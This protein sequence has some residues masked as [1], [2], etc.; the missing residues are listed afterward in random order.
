MR[1]EMGEAAI[2][3]DT[4]AL[5]RFLGI[6]TAIMAVQA[7]AAAL[8]ALIEGRFAAKVGYRFRD[9]FARYF[10]R[11]PFSQLEKE[12][13]G[14]SLSIYTN[15]LPNGANF[16]SRM[17]LLVAADI[18]SLLVTF[19]YMVMLT[20]GLTLLFFAMFPVLVVMQVLI[21]APLQKKQLKMS[22]ERTRF[23][24]I[25][26]D[27]L[28]NTS[29]IAAYSLEEVL[30]RRYMDAY[31][32]FFDAL[33]DFIKSMSTMVIAGI[34]ASLT[35]MLLIFVLAASRV[36]NGNMS[37]AEYMAFTT[38]AFQ[39]GSW[40]MMLSQRL[41]QVQVSAAGAKALNQHTADMKDL[42][43]SEALPVFSPP[44][45]VNTAIAFT[46]VNFA[47]TEEGGEVLS[48]IDLTI[49]KGTKVAFVG[50]SGSGKSTLLKLMLG[51]YEPTSG[52]VS[53]FGSQ[54]I[55][56]NAFAYVPQDSFLFPESI[57]ANITGVSVGE[58]LSNKGSSKHETSMDMTK[59]E[60]ACRDAGIWDFINS[61]PDKFEG[62]LTEA[63]E[64]VSGGQKQRIALARAFYQDAP[65]VL[66]DEATS[67]LDPTT[68]AEV[69]TSFEKMLSHEP[70][71]TVVM[72]AHRPKAI[73]FCDTIVMMENGKIVGMGSHES[74]LETCPEYARLE[75]SNGN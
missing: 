65:I 53:V 68:E 5:L 32:K 34:M 66:F 49:E 2:A 42:E 22:E 39:C 71:K 51:L 47:Y 54:E 55:P 16:A 36:I 70:D 21:S 61:L 46:N 9:N 35:P 44:A 19:I 18:I 59:L 27:S 11:M 23:N 1:G 74:L 30:K 20:P 41:T 69:L 14:A 38:L 43:L 8:S 17:G 7:L 57:G 40:L 64:N 6:L 48:G 25:V 13:S 37:I 63:A 50:G 60:T 15:D 33:R 29:T 4:G 12:Q 26:N 10:L 52:Q 24:A 28:Q 75:V 73:A 31:G 58:G 45:N 72:V 62:Q 56:I 3:A 67:A